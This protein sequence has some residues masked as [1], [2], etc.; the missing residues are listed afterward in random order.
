MNPPRYTLRVSVK[1]LGKA[2]NG[3]E[4][5]PSIT[6]GQIMV[7]VKQRW[8]FL[9]LLARDFGSEA[10]AEAFLTQ[11]QGGLWNIAIE[12][13]IAFNPYFERRSIT[14]SAD[15]EEAARNLAKNFG[16][17][18][19]IE[20]VH[21]LSDEEGYTIFQ[22]G[23][24]IRYFAIHGGHAYV[25]TGW[26]SVSKTLAEGFQNVRPIAE[27]QDT[28]LTTAIDLYLA[29]FYETAIRARF[30]TLMMCLEVLA[31]VTEKHAAAV[32][33]LRW[34]WHRLPS[35]RWRRPRNRA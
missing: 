22:S 28:G 33:A 8:P 21:G 23:E 2:I 15:P 16:F 14:R 18:E 35:V 9:I 24:N 26:D 32:R 25:S 17:T 30:L 6:V 20:P 11:I 7:T 1:V 12:H 31:P 27:G 4:T 34:R 3:L 13:N 19:P 10:D 29:N 5:E